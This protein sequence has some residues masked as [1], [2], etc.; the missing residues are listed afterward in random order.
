MIRV[1][2]HSKDSL[3]S[4]G[5]RAGA[6]RNGPVFNGTG[7][8]LNFPKTPHLAPCSCCGESTRQPVRTAYRMQRCL[9]ALATAAMVVA[10]AVTAIAIAA[11]AVA[12]A[13]IA[14]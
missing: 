5:Y 13:A 6:L 4:S 9:D 3:R 8:V 7:P 12:V 1:L 14:A 11:V 2:R 10:V